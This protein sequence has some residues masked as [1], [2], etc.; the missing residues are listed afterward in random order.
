MT[1]DIFQPIRL[2]YRIHDKN[3]LNR[4]FSNLSCMSSDPRNER[5]VWLYDGEAKA[6]KFKKSYSAIPKERRPIVL[7]SFYSSGDNEMHLDVG[8][9]ERASKAIVFFDKRLKRTVAEV[10]YFAIYN[11][12][13][14]QSEHPGSNFDTLFSE[15]KTDE[16][17]ANQQAA[18]ERMKVAVKAGA[19]MEL[20]NDRSFKLVEAGPTNFYEDGIKSFE[21]S[22]NMR[23][24]VAV[25]RWQGE[26]DFVFNDIIRAIANNKN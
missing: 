7:G 1:G 4:I 5:W 3:A 19:F 20:L 12:L 25:K 24:H 18:I 11:K 6:L 22:L 10:T 14:P 21:T 15:V 16:I 26:P 13:L 9:I 23:Q 17:K 8:S 2:Y